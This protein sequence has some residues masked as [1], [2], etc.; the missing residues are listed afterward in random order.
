M[1]ASKLEGVEINLGQGVV[2][3]FPEGMWTENGVDK[4]IDVCQC[5]QAS[6]HSDMV[7]I[8]VFDSGTVSNAGVD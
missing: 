3:E 8:S 2:I 5:A 7:D 4:I 6:T 1:S